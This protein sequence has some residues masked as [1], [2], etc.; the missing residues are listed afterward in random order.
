MN[1]KDICGAKQAADASDIA[2]AV[3]LV[4][5]NSSDKIVETFPDS[6]IDARMIALKDKTGSQFMLPE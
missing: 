1:K 3:D 4:A 2:T 6:A 5:I